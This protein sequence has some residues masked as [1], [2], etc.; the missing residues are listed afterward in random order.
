MSILENDFGDDLYDPNIG[1]E[2]ERLENT[3]IELAR[4]INNLVA[5]PKLKINSDM[6]EAVLNEAGLKPEEIE[7]IISLSNGILPTHNP[8]GAGDDQLEKYTKKLKVC[9]T[10]TIKRMD[11]ADVK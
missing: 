6:A 4:S 5:D 11:V 7:D 8:Y 10:N 9:L 2:E 3:R 1:E